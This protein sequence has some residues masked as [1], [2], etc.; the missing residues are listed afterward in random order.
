MEIKKINEVTWEIPKEG[1]MNVTGRVFLS[2]KLLES[3][4]KDRSLEQVRN[5]ASMPGIL[6]HWRGRGPFRERPA[7]SIGLEGLRKQI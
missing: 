7:L 5:V 1:N 2:E 3:V 6:K 4:K